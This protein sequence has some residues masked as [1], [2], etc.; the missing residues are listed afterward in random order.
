MSNARRLSRS[1]VSFRMAKSPTS[2]E[3]RPPP[4]NARL[5]SVPVPVINDL[6]QSP[7]ERYIAIRS[8]MLY[9]ALGQPLSDP[10]SPGVSQAPSVIIQTKTTPGGRSLGFQ[11][12]ADT[13]STHSK[14]L[15]PAYQ[16]QASEFSTPLIITNTNGTPI[17]Q[18]VPDSTQSTADYPMG[19]ASTITS[20]STLRTQMSHAQHMQAWRQNRA[21]KIQKHRPN[22]YVYGSPPQRPME[23]KLG[24][25]AILT[26]QV[27][28]TSPQPQASDGPQRPASSSPFQFPRGE[29]RTLNETS[30]TRE[31]KS[32]RTTA[33]VIHQKD[34]QSTTSNATEV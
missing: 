34:S 2:P 10:R 11:T 13:R 27:I 32:L 16:R 4:L 22:C 5:L 20:S 21:R 31:K 1:I 30:R 33:A 9:D 15:R 24:T 14:D 17:F 18:P 28:V 23:E 25:A 26:P 19:N 6:P 3:L 8:C 29:V 12:G 7:A